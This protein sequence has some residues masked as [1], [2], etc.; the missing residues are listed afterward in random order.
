[1]VPSATAGTSRRNGIPRSR[2][3]STGGSYAPPRG[4]PCLAVVALEHRRHGGDHLA[5]VEAHDPHAGG[6]AA[7]AGDAAHLHADDRATGVD[8]EDLV[9]EL[10]HEGRH[11]VALLGRELDGPDALAAAAL[12][13]EVLGLGALAVAGIGDDE[14]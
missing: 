11:H 1:M 2:S 7:L 6:V 3:S 8:H 12:D 9:V 13:V 14:H 5:V 4:R 10:D